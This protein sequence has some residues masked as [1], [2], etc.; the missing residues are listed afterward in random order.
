MTSF[1]VHPARTISFDDLLAGLQAA[2]ANRLV[3][4]RRGSDGLLLYV[5]SEH[6]VFEGAWDGITI[7]ARG[8]ILD[9]AARR[10]VA[11]PFPKFFNVGERGQPIPDL[12][13]ETFEKLDG[14]LIIIYHHGGRWRAATKGAFDSQQAVWAQARLDGADLS[15]LRPGTTYL[16]EATYAEN[17]IVVRYDAP[18]LVMLG[19]YA[20]DGT[21]LETGALAA[22]AAGLGWPMAER[23]A[24]SSVSDLLLHAQGLP[25]SREGFVLRFSDGLR[26]KVKGNEYKRIHALISRVT[27]LAMWEA[28]A[29][30]DDMAAIRRDLPE[31]FW[32]DFDNIVA[33]LEGTVQD[34]SS[35]VAALAGT[36]EGLS[37]KE[38]GLRFDAMDAD[39]RPFI[40]P[41]R[42]AG[43]KLLEG[44][45]RQALFKAVRPTGNVLRGYVPSY[46]LG[47]VLSEA[48]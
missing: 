5:Y 21:E 39:L 43:G 37:D 25:R 10:V 45:A 7:A 36:L 14:S 4:E 13:F 1:L 48:S 40:F 11:T 15:P 41:Y 42:K 29:A 28:M 44:R 26:L 19:A 17:R 30:G 2:R 38:V 23:H 32:D 6:C 47:R 22:I 20:E 34:L 3:Y 33:L 35:R 9:P 16:A 8:L 31:E 46:A 12:P 24:F 27:P 18:A